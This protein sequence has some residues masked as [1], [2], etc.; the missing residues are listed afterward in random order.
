MVPVGLL[1][2]NDGAKKSPK[3][4]QKKPEEKPNEK[5]KPAIADLGLFGRS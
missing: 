5:P 4:K 1:T 3:N 2:A